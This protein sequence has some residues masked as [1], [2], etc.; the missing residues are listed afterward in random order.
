[1]RHDEQW[2]HVRHIINVRCRSEVGQ[3]FESKSFQCDFMDGS[4][5][6]VLVL[7]YSS[8]LKYVFE[9]LGF[10][11]EDHWPRKPRT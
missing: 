1:M 4:V 8:A 6:D 10:L 11:P 9:M 7:C 3:K 5:Q 2:R